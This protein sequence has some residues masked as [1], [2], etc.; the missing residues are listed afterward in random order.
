MQRRKFIRAC[1]GGAALGAGFPLAA[2][3]ARTSRGPVAVSGRQAGNPDA[4]IM[5]AMGELRTIYEPPLVRQMLASGMDSITITLCDPK[6]VGAEA[7]E[8]A[9]DSLLEYDR[10]LERHPELFIKATSVADVDRAKAEGKLAVFYLYQNSVQ[11]GDDLDRGR[12]VPRSR[13][14]QQ[15]DHVQ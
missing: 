12:D 15:S 3:G 14:P 8:L 7:L 11:F 2:Q 10:Y 5:D 1:A 9:V 4:L 13:G 6:P